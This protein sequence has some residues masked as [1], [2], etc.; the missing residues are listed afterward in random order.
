MP[1]YRQ[2]DE[3][4]R[5]AILSGRLEPGA[6]LPSSRSLADDLGISRS[7]VLGAY[8]QLLAEG[9][10]QAREG[11][12]T[13]VTESIP[14]HVHRFGSRRPPRQNEPERIA[15]AV[16]ELSHRGLTLSRAGGDFDTHSRPA[17]PFQP[18]LPASADFPLRAWTRIGRGIEPGATGL[19]HDVRGDGEL[20][21][22][23][24]EYLKTTRGTACTPEQILITTGAQQAL[25]LAVQAF[26]D[27]G[28]EVWLED[29]G[30]LSARHA[31]RGAGVR[32]VP[33]PVDKD[34][35]DVAAGLARAPRARLAYVSPS[36]QFPL[37]V[38]MS[39]PRRLALLDWAYEN[40]AWII[41]DDYD[42]EYRFRGRPLQ[43]LQGLDRRGRVIY[44]GTFS[45]ACFPV[46]RV[47]YLVAAEP[48]AEALM[49]TRIVL[50]GRI[51][52]EG[53]PPLLVQRTLARFI[54]DGHLARYLRVQRAR[55]EASREALAE[56]LR[57]ELPDLLRIEPADAGVHLVA[58]LPPE[59]DDH[60]VV[61]WARAAGVQV[62]P[63]SGFFLEGRA[64]SGLI[65]GFASFT[66]DEIRPAVAALVEAIRDALAR[67]ALP[68][69]STDP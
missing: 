29:P 37:G 25:A 44:L 17:G 66:P 19:Q 27:P 69:A 48:L 4:L 43:A 3:G 51:L 60:Q 62:F 14:E 55:T 23:I 13:F 36:H 57:D 41:E 1:L 61:A 6:R 11:S 2:L 42:S 33:I 22:A 67:A 28:D 24:A 35:L 58:W 40:D 31:F 50:E 15:P 8:D 53:Q 49:T 47:G 32:V 18:G 34:G 12:G 9:Y 54:R 30:Y 5:S 64:R 65:F 59:L 38:S 20:R 7:T 16:A 45:N 68:P 46:A 21:A 26:L 10:L 52:F 63:L 56:A 39:L